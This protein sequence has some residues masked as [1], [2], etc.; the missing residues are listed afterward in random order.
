MSSVPHTDPR[1]AFLAAATWHG[2]LA[3]AEALLARHPEIAGR[4]AAIVP[5]Q[6]GRT[7]GREESRVFAVTA[8]GVTGRV[9]SRLRG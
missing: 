4:G 1:T 3:P 5:T 2:D 8:P 6:A 7:P 9:G